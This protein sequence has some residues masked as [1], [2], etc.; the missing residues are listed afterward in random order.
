[1]KPAKQT[2]PVADLPPPADVPTDSPPARPREVARPIDVIAFDDTQSDPKILSQMIAE[3]NRLLARKDLSIDTWRPLLNQL[4]TLDF[5]Q[6]KQYEKGL[7]KSLYLHM[8][9]RNDIS[10]ADVPDAWLNL[11]DDRFGWFSSG[12][13]FQRQ[14]PEYIGIWKKLHDCYS[15]P[16]SGTH[17]HHVPPLLDPP[18]PLFLR[19]WALILAYL[20]LTFVFA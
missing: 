3:S 12:L 11:I 14:H 20:G 2:A 1:M 6:E 17:A 10:L 9:F 19:W 4:V 8:V 16:Q 13:D 15:S 7:V 5:A 18:V